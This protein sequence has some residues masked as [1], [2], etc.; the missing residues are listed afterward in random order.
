[1]PTRAETKVPNKN[2]GF[3]MCAAISLKCFKAAPAIIGVAKKNEN[4]AAASLVK[5]KHL[6]VVIVIPDLE[7]PGIKA[8]ACEHPIIIAC[9]KVSFFKFIFCKQIL[10][11]R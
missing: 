6:A 9:E 4:L 10:S 2:N 11:T 8:K 3:I 5:P 1:M 7:T